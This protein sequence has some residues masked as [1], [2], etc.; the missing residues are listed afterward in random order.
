MA[1]T[2]LK[3]T[4]SNFRKPFNNGGELAKRGRMEPTPVKA[5]TNDE[6]LSKVSKFAPNNVSN[7]R[8]NLSSTKFKSEVKTVKLGVQNTFKAPTLVSNVSGLK[9][10]TSNITIHK[11]NSGTDNLVS[12]VT[13]TKANSGT[14]NNTSSIKTISV[15]QNKLLSIM[16]SALNIDNIPVKYISTVN[17]GEFVP[18]K[19]QYSKLDLD[20][21]PTKYI[22]QPSR[23]QFGTN[24]PG[25]RPNASR[26]DI[27][28]IPTRY[29]NIVGLG[30]FIPDKPYFS[31]LDIDY[32][33][34]KYQSI[35]GLGKFDPDRPTLSILDIDSIPTQYQNTVGLGK[36]DPDKPYFSRLDIDSIPTQYQNIVGLGQ[37]NPDLPTLSR[38][39]I[40]SIPTQYQ[41]I[42]GLGQFNPDK[43]YFSR[44]DIDSIPDKYQ[45]TV[46]LGK[47]DP[48]SPRLS[49]LDIDYIP[50]LY[51]QL[52]G[53]GKFNNDSTIVGNRWSGLVPP[54]VNFF[55][56]DTLLGTGAK[57]FTTKMDTTQFIGISNNLYAFTNTIQKPLSN[58]VAKL[59]AQ[60]GIGSVFRY[61]DAGAPKTKIFSSKGY[62]D[63][64]RYG[65][66]VRSN[67]A[68]PN[69]SLMYKL[70][71]EHNSPSALDL[72]YQKFNLQDDSYNPW[73][74]KE[75]Y[76]VRGIQRKKNPTPQRWGGSAL[77]DEGLIRG[78]MAASVERSIFD[79]A[80]LS[81][82]ITSPK[83]LLWTAK[84][85]GL[86]LSNP[87]VETGLPTPI[88][89]TRIHT[90]LLSLASV[91]TT[92][93]GVHISNYGI[94][95]LNDAGRY[96][97]V[98]T[99][100]Y[101]E[102]EIGNTNSNRLVSLKNE[103]F[104]TGQTGIIM[105]RS[106]FGGPNST[107]GIGFTNFSRTVNTN[108]NL[109]VSTNNP[110]I[111]YA[112][113]LA[114][115]ASTTDINSSGPTGI[116]AASVSSTISTRYLSALYIA[117]NKS[118][119]PNKNAPNPF[120]RLPNVNRGTDK[121]T[122][123]EV[124]DYGNGNNAIKNY[125]TLAYGKIPDDITEK[126]SNNGGFND[127]R[128]DL[129]NGNNVASTFNTDLIAIQHKDL[130][131]KNTN[132]QNF[133]WGTQGAI[134]KQKADYTIASGRGDKVNLI[135]YDKK[136]LAQNI[137][138][139]NYASDTKDFIA[140]YFAG[141]AH[142]LGNKDDVMIF[143][144]NIKSFTD[145]FN[146]EWSAIT[147]MGRADKAYLY[148]GFERS[149][150]FTFMVAATSREEMKPMWRK[151][152]ALS[153]YT[154]PTY[155]TG[156]RM[157]GPFMRITIGNLFQNSPGFIASLSVSIPDE[158]TWEI[159][160]EDS[161]DMLQLPTMA[162]ISV[163]FKM[164]ADYRP[165]KNGR[166]YS[167]SHLGQNDAKNNWLAGVLDT[168]NKDVSINEK[169]LTGK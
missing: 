133:G 18:D 165:Q 85:I 130:R 25:E 125:A 128:D 162:E 101:I 122:K 48:D 49:N 92:A 41:N 158:A 123:I 79:V 19:S 147:I 105:S 108:S 77:A 148:T 167:L 135:D 40:D 141:P 100:K 38:L 13:I 73:Y 87:I 89:Q 136:G 161:L 30:E 139:G 146:P 80:R 153:T 98:Q 91:P 159:N 69:E 75:P 126:I 7:T 8:T 72:Q 120:D 24:G 1:L 43:Y 44:L 59:D 61:T 166:A 107:Y 81:Q 169:D 113:F 33:P 144:A 117:G 155:N 70:S 78:G 140:F 138:K 142:H 86:G 96:S 20:Y 12:P 3:S 143:R 52:V 106:S 84:Q 65:D 62:F 160:L 88:G 15:T 93:F 156:G 17:S 145:S 164:L 63:G 36:F 71:T 114:N 31:R 76:V 60:L 103:L 127:F 64:H 152:N 39:D 151:I 35:V 56:P 34:V 111:P 74:F 112:K 115:Q 66:V 168:A 109:F 10:E 55:R 102:Y 50:N 104:T 27:D 124:A 14:D 32:T 163:T 97:N 29:Q 118:E 57:G 131:Y 68:N 46:N 129:T 37:F 99:V 94:P 132:F 110:D 47:F 26:L 121:D 90:G 54:A 28:S 154:M 23:L 2:D 58:G 6:T 157:I 95:F 119:N 82:W 51:S 42:V 11:A 4:L 67:N 137:A 16:N 45:N 22:L 149:I 83:G 150:S 134:G 21:I 9:N 53:N 5:N 116:N